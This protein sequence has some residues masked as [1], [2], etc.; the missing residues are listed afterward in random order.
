M[1]R[2]SAPRA[3]SSSSP[4]A[5]GPDD[6]VLC[7]ISGGASA[8]LALPAPGLSLD[9]KQAVNRALLASGADIG[10]MN[11]V[12]KHLSAIKGGRLAA[13]A[14]PAR[15]VSLLISDV[16]G[17]EPAVIGSGPT[18]PD[19]PPSRTRWRSSSATGSSRRQRVR[20]HLRAA[21]DETPKPGDPRL[22]RAET[23]VVA[24]PQAS[25][26]AAAALA[27]ERGLNAL[28]LSDAIEGEAREVAKVMAAIALQAR[29]HG[30]PAAPPCVLLSG[31]ETTVTVRGRG[32]GGRNA[33]FLLALAVQLR[34]APG[35]SAL[36]ADTDGIDG[37][38][39]NAGALVAPD[40]L[41]RA[42]AR[43]STPG[44]CSPTTTATASSARSATCGHRAD[45][46]QR[47]RLPCDPGRSNMKGRDN[48]QLPDRRVGSADRAARAADPHPARHRDPARVTAA[49]ICDGD[50]HI[51]DG[52]FD[53]GDGHR[54]E[55]AK[56]GA[57]LPLTL[58]HEI[59]GV[60]EALGPDA[61]GR[62]GSATRRVAF[63][64]IGCRQCAV[65]RHEREQWCLTPKFLGARV[66]G[67]YSDHVIVPHPT[68]WCPTRHAQPRSP[69]PTPAPGSPPTAR[70]RK[71]PRCARTTTWCM[72][73]AGGVGLS[74][75]Q[76][77]P[78]VVPARLIVAD[79][80]PEKRAVARQAGAFETIDNGEPERP[81][82]CSS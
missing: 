79:V 11:A 9:D 37:S 76:I 3:G 78:A 10:Q 64:W 18:V 82:R 21:A 27:R 69:A 22:A 19:P 54:A 24:K 25:L 75:V 74:G 1:P 31:G 47:Q 35:I 4:P 29:R 28:I 36:A 57:T 2:A 53:L 8:L 49:G 12:R 42:E 43:A 56:L 17:D 39:D 77:A 26:E 55:L 62:R 33:E 52:Y 13:A 72:I 48:A 50:L 68:T 23:I 41:A 14:H 80:D 66:P 5:P 73:G 15:V 70:S 44:R 16:P 38:E 71:S 51:N 65:C 46:H 81:R 60:V 30:Q 6:L 20:E 40:T 32:R 45:A 58:G 59:V 63:P 7:L 67:G 34:A 61:K